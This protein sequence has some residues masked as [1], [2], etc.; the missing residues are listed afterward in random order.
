MPAAVSRVTFDTAF[1]QAGAASGLENG[2]EEV[3]YR[4]IVPPEGIPVWE[5]RI[6]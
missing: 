1:L 5:K 4:K 2:S 6:G 3:F